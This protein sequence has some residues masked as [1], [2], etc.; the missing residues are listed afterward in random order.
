M[1]TPPQRSSELLHTRG[2]QLLRAFTDRRPSGNGLGYWSQ[3]R[4]SLRI[5]KTQANF[6]ACR[7]GNLSDCQAQTCRNRTSG[8]RR[9]ESDL[10]C[11]FR[12]AQDSEIILCT[13]KMPSHVELSQS[14]EFSRGAPAD[15][16]DFHLHSAPL[17]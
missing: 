15:R 5:Q 11:T 10:A 16:L 4:L 8:P 13:P 2:R 3:G 7:L 1:K 6:F 14:D 9:R 12:V 17:G